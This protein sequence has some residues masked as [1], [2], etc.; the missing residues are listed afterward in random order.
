M[1][2]THICKVNTLGLI[3]SVYIEIM[4]HYNPIH[5]GK[6][7]FL[8]LVTVRNGETKGKLQ[9]EENKVPKSHIMDIFN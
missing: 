5:V 4:I 9:Y 1:K 3:I 2:Y 6:G 7:F 8:V